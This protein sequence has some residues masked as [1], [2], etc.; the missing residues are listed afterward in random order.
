ML[1]ED[2]GNKTY[3]A[4]VWQYG[5]KDD[6]LTQVAHFDP[7]RFMSGGP[8]FITHDEESCGIIPAEDPRRG[9]YLLDA[10]VHRTNP[11]PE[12]VEYGQFLALFVPSKG[13]EHDDDHHKGK[14]DDDTNGDDDKKNGD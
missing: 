9:W 14:H 7:A 4:R 5:I 13:N 1:Q 3:L 6:T 10:Q 8:G 2:P 11:D 12:L